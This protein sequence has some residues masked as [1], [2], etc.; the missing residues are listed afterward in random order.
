MP[1]K[2][3]VAKVVQVP[4]NQVID[5]YSYDSPNPP[6]ISTTVFNTIETT[7]PVL[8]PVPKATVSKPTMYLQSS[9]KNS[10]RIQL[11]QAINNFT[12]KGSELLSAMSKFDT[13]K[14]EVAN[15]DVLI[16]TKKE[17]HSEAVK[18]LEQTYISKTKSLE[19]QFIEYEKTA[20]SKYRDATKKLE[21]EH[22]DMNKSLQNKYTDVN[23]RLEDDYHDKQRNLSNEFKN[24]QLSIKQKLAEFKLKSCE[25][26]LK[27]VQMTIVKTEEYQSLQTLV[28]KT[29]AELVEL[30]RSFT[31]ESDKIR[32]EEKQ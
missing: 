11:V 7:A 29:N 14:E 28:S 25:E 9:S 27:D 4:T 32:Q 6:S 23:K 24:E 5:E 1:P 18:Q 16:N 15:Y 17:E 20:T 21:S 31:Q 26:F 13:F 22:H 19:E 2:K 8:I 30:K 10:D 3:T 12:L